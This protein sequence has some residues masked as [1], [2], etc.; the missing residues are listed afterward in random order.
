MLSLV[1]AIS[2]FSVRANKNCGP[3]DNA[4][5]CTG[6]VA[7]AHA[8]ANSTY[9]LPWKMDGTTSL[10]TWYGVTC[11][12][13]GRATNLE[14][15]GEGLS[16]IF[17]T[18]VGLLTSMQVFELYENKLSGTLP[19]QVARLTALQELPLADNHLSGTIPTEVGLLTALTHLDLSFNDWHSTLPAEVGRL[20]E[21][22][23]LYAYTNAG[24]S[25]T[26]P[27]SICPLT[28][29]GKLGD[30]ELQ[31]VPFACPLPACADAC[32]AVC[33]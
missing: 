5:D 29:K 30:C 20:T 11:D 26:M 7:F 12:D 21:L 3:S 22:D 15:A 17:P 16:G 24:V 9:P 25:G 27:S 14:L 23:R 6:L 2:G 8:T 4:D 18:E 32:K 10:C 31:Q 1:P 19:T 13:K 33:K 28:T